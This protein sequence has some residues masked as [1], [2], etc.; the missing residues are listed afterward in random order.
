V[1]HGNEVNTLNAWFVV[2]LVMVR[3]DFASSINASVVRIA[4]DVAST[5]SCATTRT[6]TLKNSRSTRRERRNQPST[7]LIA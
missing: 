7:R 4:H 5:T 3:L 1:V 6:P 2:L